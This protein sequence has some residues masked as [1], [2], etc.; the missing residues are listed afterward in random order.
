MPI[1]HPHSDSGAQHN[2]IDS[3]P[4]SNT[5][6][7]T[8]GVSQNQESSQLIVQL[9][10]TALAAAALAAAAAVRQRSAQPVLL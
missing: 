3:M 8:A 7:D 6:P 9:P 4:A 1:L 2:S 10:L 5:Q